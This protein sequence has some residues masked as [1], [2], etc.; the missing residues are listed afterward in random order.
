MSTLWGAILISAISLR[1]VSNMNQL[2]LSKR[3]KNYQATCADLITMAERELAAFFRAVTELFGSNHTGPS[4]EDWLQELLATKDL[5][6]SAR[7][8][9]LLTVKAAARLSQ[10]TLS[11]MHGPGQPPLP[12]GRADSRQNKR[13]Q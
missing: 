2:A 11:A 10:V 1:E 6:A 8:W 7:E 12:A 9:Q 13:Q 5:P 4:A 3:P